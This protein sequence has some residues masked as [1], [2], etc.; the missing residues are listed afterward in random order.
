MSE[1]E[2]LFSI[3]QVAIGL[4]GFSA[5]V[6]GFKRLESG[7]WHRADADRFNGML[8]HAMCAALFCVL[9]RENAALRAQQHRERVEHDMESYVR[10]GMCMAAAREHFTKL[11]RL[12][13]DESFARVTVSDWRAFAATQPRPPSRSA[14][15]H[16]TSFRK[17]FSLSA[18]Q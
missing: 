14:A 8:I 1:S 3:A 10:A 9:R 18:T 17:T 4:A 15:T 2:T 12:S 7:D 13:D 11:F 16:S 5:I 6:V